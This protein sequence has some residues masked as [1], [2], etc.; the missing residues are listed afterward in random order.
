[1]SNSNRDATTF[2]SHISLTRGLISGMRLIVILAVMGILPACASRRVALAPVPAAA[3]APAVDVSHLIQQGCYRCLEEAFDRARDAAP[4]QAFEAAV[5]LALRSKELGL[6]PERWLEEART[7]SGGDAARTL[8]LTIADAVPPHPLSGARDQSAGIGP[9]GPGARE[10]A[11][12]WRE[13]LATGIAS[14]AFRK[15]LDLAVQCSIVRTLAGDDE[16]ARIVEDAAAPP[17]VKYRAALCSSRFTGALEALRQADEQ[18]VD[19]D[20]PLG[21][22]ALEDRQTPDPDE[23]MRRFQSARRAFPGSPAIATSTGQL[24]LAWEEWAP[25]VAAFDAALA[26]VPIHPDALIGRTVALSNLGQHDAAIAAATI[27]I[28]GARWFL[29]QAH[30]WRAWNYFALKNYPV[31]RIEADRARTLMVNSALFVLSGLI[32]WRLE[33]RETAEGEFE[34]AL[35]MDF[36]QCE[37]ATYLGLVRNERAKPA[38]ALAAFVQ[39]RQCYDLAISVRNEAIAALQRGPGTEAFKAREV[40][41]HTRVLRDLEDRR[42]EAAN[43]IEQLQKFLTSRQDR[44]AAPVR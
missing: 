35:K 41:R 30:Y 2:L 31:A 8:Y 9:A 24:Y 38:E 16:I 18:F 6:P 33:K 25:A 36:G 7:L 21:A 4:G 1:M 27:L 13:A 19:I 3:A 40:G 20:Y 39:A 34:E 44:P 26:L 32:D 5:L 11:P 10:R 37:A 23:A 43:N 42:A 28:E 22:R 15:Y 17:L 29:G 14:A 12:Q